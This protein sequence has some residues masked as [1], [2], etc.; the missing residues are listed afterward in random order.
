MLI[1]A[2]ELEADSVVETDVCVIGTG[3]AGTTV[4]HEMLRASRDVVLLEGGGLRLERAAQDTYRGQVEDAS[5]HDR[6]ELVRQ[7]RLGG[8]TTQWGGRCIPL[9]EID[10]EQRSY[11]EHS[12]WPITRDDLEPYYRR[13]QEYCRAGAYEYDAADALPRTGPLVLDGQG[14]DRICDTKL[15]RWSPPVDFGREYQPLFAASDHLRLVHH[16]NVTRLV[17]AE[18]SGAVDHVV[19]SPAPGRR[20]TVRA[21]TFVLAAGGLETARA[22]LASGDAATAGVGNEYGLVGR[23]YMLH[24]VAEVGR[25]RFRGPVPAHARGF[26]RSRDGVWCRRMLW[27]TAGTQRELGLRNIAFAFWFPD[28]QDP[29][30]GDPLLSA[31]SVVRSTMARTGIDWKSKGVQRRYGAKGAVRPH[32]ANIARG[33]PEVARFAPRWVNERWRSDRRVP[34]FMTAG[35]AGDLRLRF[36]AEQSP[37][38][39]NRV[40]LTRDRDAFGVPRLAVHHRVSGTD[41]ESIVRSL[42][43]VHGELERLGVAETGGAPTASELPDVAFGDATHQMGLTRMAD[44]PRHGV[45]DRDCRVHGTPNVFV[46]S[47]AVFPTSGFGGPTLTIVALAIRVADRIRSEAGR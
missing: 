27:V 44:S 10:F 9:E 11:V 3:A 28:P 39:E 17:R 2:R 38:A 1:D 45:V 36:D 4:A 46:A 31:F 42:G 24:P 12:G 15:W 47:S 41:R 13:A 19:V 43:V 14:S 33:L 26:E 25:L 16:A 37:E 20:V 8:T 29:A 5:P 18:H 30:H 32:L 40:V 35:A 22:L 6:L 23:Y 7:K 34:S 21:R